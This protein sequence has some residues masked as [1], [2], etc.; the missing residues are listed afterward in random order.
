VSNAHSS[1]ESRR[2]Y[3]NTVS[4]SGSIFDYWCNDVEISTPQAADTT[5]KGQ[6][7]RGTFAPL[8]LGGTTTGGGLGFTL[9]TSD[10]E[11]PTASATD[12]SS[13]G[14]DNTDGGGGSKSKTGAIVG[15][16]VGGV[17][18]VGL[19]G[20]GAFFLLRKK[21]QGKPTPAAANGPPTG[22]NA[23]T[24]FPPTSPMAQ[25][26][27]GPPGGMTPQNGSVYDPVYAAQ[28]QQQQQQQQQGSQYGTPP[29]PNGT[30]GTN[31]AYKPEYGGY[32][33]PP[34]GRQQPTGGGPV[35]R[36]ESMSPMTDPHRM[37][38]AAGAV[39]LQSPTP[40]QAGSLA[41]QGFVP[42]QAYPQQQQQQQQQQGYQQTQ[43][44]IHEA[45]GSQ[46]DHHRGQMHELA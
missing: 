4:F 7:N 43:P 6:S 12:G 14:D 31:G 39:P 2:P 45:G 18:V 37:S 25:S 22:S 23:A 26:A 30:N 13:D 9:D 27:Y 8:V 42:G 29:P 20:L 40:S 5:F 34:Q 46:V 32:Y 36:H 10:I 28:M 33:P 35:D 17:A 41:G 15:G 3:C 38:N 1:S 11:S 21:H 24:T 19:V 44:T 16:V